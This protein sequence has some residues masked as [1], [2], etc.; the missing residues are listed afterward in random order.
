M[1]QGLEIYGSI[2]PDIVQ[3]QLGALTDTAFGN[4]CICAIRDILASFAQGGSG[5][6]MP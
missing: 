2:L 5:F 4:H 3:T 6:E 1:K